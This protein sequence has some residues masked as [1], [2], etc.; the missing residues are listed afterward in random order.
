MIRDSDIE[1][2]EEA[3]DL[4]LLFETALKRRRR[5]SV[6]RLEVNAAMPED[7][8]RLRHRASSTCSREDVFV[9]DGLLGLA[10]HRQLIVDDRPD[11]KFPPYNARFPER[12]RDYRRRLLRR[13]P[14]RRTSSSTIP[15]RASTWWCSSCARR[16]AIPPWWRSSRR[17]TAPATTPRSSRR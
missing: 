13:H 16:R 4:V 8:L 6:I 14:R 15:T 17:S 10:E 2:E 7:L 9:Q 12:I 1:I 3:E 5:G 11:L